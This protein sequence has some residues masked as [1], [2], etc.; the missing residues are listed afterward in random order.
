MARLLS[1][2]KR[3]VLEN[4]T[5]K[6]IALVLATATWYAI[7]EE[8]SFKDWVR[9]VP[10][11][12]LVDDGWAVLDRSVTTVDV[13]FQGTQHAVSGLEPELVDIVVDCRG[14]KA[15]NAVEFNL[16]P[17]MVKVPAGARAIEL[18]PSEITLTLGQEGSKKLPVKAEIIGNP[19]AGYSLGEVVCEPLTVVASGPMQKLQTIDGVRTAPID[20]DGRVRSFTISAAVAQPSDRWEAQINP[21]H[22]KVQVEIEE[23]SA[24]AEFENMKVK[25]LSGM[26]DGRISRIRPTTVDV[27]VSGRADLLEKLDRTMISA[28]IDCSELSGA[29]SYELP[30][31]L[32]LPAGLSEM[33]IRPP[34]VK[35]NLSEP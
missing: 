26:G 2:L 13:L 30:V 18:R 22:V 24:T 23:R 14:Q 19:P 34:S 28:Y 31:Q 7:Q 25:A 15:E 35:V 3:V 11:R 8:I 9:D 33:E 10:V 12:V 5:Q 29:A 21:T 6:V 20:L 32:F 1:F 4:K 17:K 27:V 16:Q